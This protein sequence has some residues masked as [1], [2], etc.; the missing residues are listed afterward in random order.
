M[1]KNFYPIIAIALII[2]TILPKLVHAQVGEYTCQ[3]EGMKM[4]GE[5]QF[6]NWSNGERL[7][8]KISDKRMTYGTNVFVYKGELVR[9]ETVKI[10]VYSSTDNSARANFYT[11]KP[12]PT[13]EVINEAFSLAGFCVPR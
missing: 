8:V 1:K 5:T 7:H 12:R 6:K 10:Y 3:F 11:T 13:L 9:N 2:T 4:P